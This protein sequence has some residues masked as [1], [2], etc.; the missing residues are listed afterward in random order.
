MK[1]W[2][3][4][5]LHEGHANNLLYSKRPFKDVDEQHQIFV[6]NF[7]ERVTKDDTV[8]HNGDFCFRNS[9]G[10]KKGEGLPIKF[11]EW[12]KDYNGKWIYLCGNHDRNNSLKT[13]IEKMYLRYGGKRICLNHFPNYADP[14]CEWNFTAHVHLLWKI[15]RLNENSIMVNIGID[16]WGYKPASFEEIMKC[17][18]EFKKKEKLL[19]GAP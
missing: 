5:D 11:S 2:F 16:Q 4:A 12:A 18:N 17:V 15:K 3:T 10:G 19:A 8:I 9:S 14:F 7:N 6:R 1:I 13:P